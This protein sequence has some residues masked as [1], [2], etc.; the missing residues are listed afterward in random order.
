MPSLCSEI[1]QTA[2]KIYHIIIP[3]SNYGAHHRVERSSIQK[4]ALFGDISFWSK[5]I[6]A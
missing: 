2:Q 1:Y 6:A 4:Q 3:M 5:Q